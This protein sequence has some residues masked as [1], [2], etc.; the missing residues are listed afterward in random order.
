MEN[1]PFEH[2]KP[3]CT[4]DRSSALLV[5]AKLKIMDASWSA[6]MYNNKDS[7][8]NSITTS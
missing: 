3:T 8:R 1:S 2:P 5:N 6:T 4:W 7:L